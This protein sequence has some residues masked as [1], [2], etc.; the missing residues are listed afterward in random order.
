MKTQ[1]VDLRLIR[2]VVQ[3]IIHHCHPERIVLFGSHAHGQTH[4]DS[5]V[6]LLI[7]MQSK[8]RPVERTIDVTK[9]LHFYPFPMDI[10]VRTPQEI[11]RRLRMGDPFYEE[12]LE[13]G[14]VLY[15]R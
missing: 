6:D 12:I 1:K 5:D 11:R 7:V 15:E 3:P 8:K 2:K 13:R 9:T 14:K 10:L 4:S